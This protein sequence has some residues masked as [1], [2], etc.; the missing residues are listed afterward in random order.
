MK[1]TNSRPKSEGSPK[2]AFTLIELLVVVLIIGILAAIALPQY[3]LT[4]EKSKAAEGLQNLAALQ[5]AWNVYIL[6]NGVPPSSF[7]DLAVTVPYTEITD[8]KITTPNWDYEIMLPSVWC[9]TP[10]VEL[11]VARRYT[12]IFSST[13]AEANYALTSCK[14]MNICL[15]RYDS[16]APGP[17]CARIF[18]AQL[19]ANTSGND[20]YA[21][22]VYKIP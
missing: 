2:K 9:G 14:G 20:W 21:T 1:T 10:A 22:S 5:K 6:E 15:Q 8:R 7:L 19:Q 13:I 11:L 4:V 16:R 17:L 18:G 12:R 3:R